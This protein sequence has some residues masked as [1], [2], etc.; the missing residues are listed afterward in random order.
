MEDLSAL[1]LVFAPVAVI[2]PL[3]DLCQYLPNDVLGDVLLLLATPP[4]DLS[5]VTLLAVLHDY[6]DP[7]ILLVNDPVIVAD[8][9]WVAKFSEDVHFRDNLLLLFLTHGAKVELLPDHDLSVAL[10]PDLAHLPE[11]S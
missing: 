2:E 7:L 5:K 11:G 3:R 9:V 6:V 4:D 10:P 1:G 8:N